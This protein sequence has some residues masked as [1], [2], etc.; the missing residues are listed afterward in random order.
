MQG[1][2]RNAH[3][4]IRSGFQSPYVGSRVR[5][6]G[7]T[8][9]AIFQRMWLCV[10]LSGDRGRKFCPIGQS[11]S[12]AHNKAEVARLPSL[13][14]STGTFPNSTKTPV[15]SMTLSSQTSV[16]IRKRPVLSCQIVEYKL[17]KYVE[18][19]RRCV[20]GDFCTFAHGQ[21]EL[22]EWN[23]DLNNCD[24]DYNSIAKGELKFS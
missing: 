12:F 21:N 20:H 23:K 22:N 14:S 9:A 19:G 11:C 16:T 15:R 24:S 4:A 5:G 2:K 7:S 6:N 17:C 8:Y 3:S 10:D 18:A 1:R 13:P